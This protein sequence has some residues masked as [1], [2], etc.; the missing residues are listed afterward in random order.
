MFALINFYVDSEKTQTWEYNWNDRCLWNPSR[1]LCR[2][3]V[4]TGTQLDLSYHSVLSRQWLV[5]SHCTWVG[6]TSVL[7][8]GNGCFRESSL[9][10]SRMISAFQKNKFKQLLSSWYGLNVVFLLTN[11]TSLQLIAFTVW[12]CALI[13]GKSIVLLALQSYYPPGYETS[14]HPYWKRIYCQGI[15]YAV[16]GTS[17]RSSQEVFGIFLFMMVFN[18]VLTMRDATD[19]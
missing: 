4:C 3:R 9:R 5:W 15:F 1:V 13:S 10:C 16:Y 14:E 6:Q 7:M 17:F 19:G 11:H 2:H 8:V 12:T 18:C